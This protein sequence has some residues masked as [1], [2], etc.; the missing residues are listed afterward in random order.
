M[1]M[2]TG[3]HMANAR[4]SKTE[5]RRLKGSRAGQSAIAW[6]ATLSVCWVRKNSRW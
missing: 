2:S 6:L 4:Q 5:S 3:R 1:S